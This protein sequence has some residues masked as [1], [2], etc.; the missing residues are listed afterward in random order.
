[1]TSATLHAINPHCVSSVHEHRQGQPESARVATNSSSLICWFINTA[2]HKRVL[3]TTNSVSFFLGF[4]RLLS[5]AVH[6]PRRAGQEPSS[7][8]RDFLLRHELSCFPLANECRRVDV[9]NMSSSLCQRLSSSI[10]TR[11]SSSFCE[12]SRLFLRCTS[13]RFW[14]LAT[15]RIFNS[16]CDR[17]QRSAN[18]YVL[19]PRPS[20][21]HYD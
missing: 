15:P 5:R 11:S 2:V 12:F 14:D 19:Q 10:C 1:M 21:A 7:K 20:T 8:E 4:G 13:T 18:I 17:P 3:A 6:F 16:F 9:H